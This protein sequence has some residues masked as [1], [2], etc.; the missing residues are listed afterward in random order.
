M[1]QV[2]L[3]KLEWDHRQGYSKKILFYSDDLHSTGNQVQ[4]VRFEPGKGVAPHHHERQTEAY[5]I[6]NGS[7]VLRIARQE[8]RAERGDVY[9]TEPGDIHSVENDFSEPFELIVFKTNYE[10]N[11]IYWD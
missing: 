7:A 10:G 1:K 6:L 3:N 11:D 4:I 8:F 5:Y 9:L 2:N